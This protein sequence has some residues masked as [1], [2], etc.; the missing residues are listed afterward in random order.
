LLDLAG[1]ACGL[2]VAEDLPDY[3]LD[4]KFRQ[5]LFLAFKEALTNVVR[6]AG[7]TQVWLRISVQDREI[8]VVVADNG[9]GFE[10]KEQRAGADGMANMKERLKSLHGSCE[11]SSETQKG[12][13]VRFQ[14]PLPKRLL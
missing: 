2:D 1:V 10:A 4:P 8:I 11:I 5:E 12:T 6:H 9:R 14:A 3:P 13:T 7:A